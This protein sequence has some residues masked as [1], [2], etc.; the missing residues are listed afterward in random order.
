ML[1]KGFEDPLEIAEIDPVL[2]IED[3]PPARRVG[4]PEESYAGNA[5]VEE[6]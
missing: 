3:D 5:L 4:A 6:L 1:G 2:G